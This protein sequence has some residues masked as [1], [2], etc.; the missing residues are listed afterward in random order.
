MFDWITH[1]IATTGYPGISFLMLA[2]NVVPPIPSELIMP[3]AGFTAAQG[4]LSLVL[5]I[6]AGGIGSLAGAV[7]WYYVGR[8]L[9]LARVERFASRH[10][11][12]LT[13]SVD[14]IR[15]ADVWFDRHG[16]KAVL[17][18]RLV[19]TVRT[20]ISIPAGL[21]GM[22][23]GRFLLYSA[24]G[25]M[26]WTGLLAVAGYL[27]ESQ[28]TRVQAYVGPVANVVVAGIVLVYLYRLVTF[29]SREPAAPDGR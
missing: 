17:L 19:P 13:L 20:L 5:V 26:V 18:G 10:G 3:L 28:Y 7:F 14:D 8:L 25:T 23:L 16:G 21:S 24:I 9:G 6:V 4:Q 22:S 2:E 15:A 1:L 12:W 29:R 27:L 11:R